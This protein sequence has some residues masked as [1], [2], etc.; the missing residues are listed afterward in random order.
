MISM[1]VGSCFCVHLDK[2]V[3]TVIILKYVVGS[4]FVVEAVYADT[5]LLCVCFLVPR[6]WAKMT[7]N[8]IFKC[9]FERNKLVVSAE[10][11]SRMTVVSACPTVS[12]SGWSV[13]R[14]SRMLLLIL[15]L[16]KSSRHILVFN[17]G[18]HGSLLR[19]AC[20]FGSG[21]ARTYPLGSFR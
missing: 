11:F 16:L 3:S 21:A 8:Q 1:L 13:T 18:P 15:H 6:L 12:V 17:D 20:L 4:L 19:K 10:N 9:I 14:K 5:L 7:G 2:A